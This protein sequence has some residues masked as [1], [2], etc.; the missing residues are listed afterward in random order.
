MMYLPRFSN[1]LRLYNNDRT[2]QRGQRFMIIRREVNALVC[3]GLIMAKRALTFAIFVACFLL[4]IS[5]DAVADELKRFRN[6]NTD[7]R[8]HSPANLEKLRAR[9]L[10]HQLI[11]NNEDKSD[12]SSRIQY[13]RSL[14]DIRN[15]SANPERSVGDS[16]VSSNELRNGL[17]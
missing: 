17:F 11:G 4:A 2:S 1:A 16:K 12:S 5:D 7:A 9:K 14:F 8:Q 3:T 10:L 6:G 13:V 15:R